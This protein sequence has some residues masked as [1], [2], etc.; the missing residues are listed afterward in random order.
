MS[1]ENVSLQNNYQISL[2]VENIKRFKTLSN[3]HEIFSTSQPF[4]ALHLLKSF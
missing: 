3:F 2:F 1:V 4:F